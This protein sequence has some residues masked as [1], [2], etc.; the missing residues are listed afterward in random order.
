MKPGC[1][2]RCDEHRSSDTEGLKPV[3][4][5]SG[6]INGN[7]FMVDDGIPF[8]FDSTMT[9]HGSKI[10]CGDS[11]FT[12]IN[13]RSDVSCLDISAT[14]DMT[15]SP[16]KTNA[17]LRQYLLDVISLNNVNLDKVLP[18][19][20]SGIKIKLYYNILDM[21]GGVVESRSMECVPKT[22]KLHETNVAD[23][24]VTS[25]SSYMIADI[26]SM[27]YAGIYQIEL[28]KLEAIVY[29]LNTK[30]YLDAGNPFYSWDQSLN[31]VNLN[32][33]GIESAE[34]PTS[35]VLIEKY[36]SYRQEFTGNVS[37]RFKFSF[38]T[39]L[40]NFIY[41]ANN[42]YDIYA[43]LYSTTEARIKA[44]EDLVA[45]LSATVSQQEDRITALENRVTTLE[46]APKVAVEYAEGV[47]LHIGELTWEVVGKMYQATETF[48]AS[49][50]LDADV[51]AGKLIAIGG[52][53][54][55]E[56]E[57]RVDT[58]ET[59]VGTL[60]TSV[61]TLETNVGTIETNVG[62]LETSVGTLE[63]TVNTV[64]ETT[65]PAMQD[66]ID[67][68]KDST[69]GQYK[70]IVKNLD[71]KERQYV[72]YYSDAAQIIK[73]DTEHSY[74][75]TPG[76]NFSASEVSTEAFKDCTNLK[77]IEFPS[78]TSIS[79]KSKAFQNTGITSLTL[80]RGISSMQANAFSNCLD[81]T[82]VNIDSSNLSTNSE[83]FSGCTNLTDVTITS[84][85]ELGTSVFKNTGITTLTIPSSCNSL[86]TAALSNCPSLVTVVCNANKLNDYIFSG[87]NA[88]QHVE[89][90]S[91][92]TSLT[93]NSFTGT[94]GVS[95]DFKGHRSSSFKSG[96]PWGAVD[97]TF[98]YA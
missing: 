20:K 13:R 77:Y 6:A 15:D 39:Y 3:Y 69:L 5:V 2:I 4:P 25:L 97:G 65:L 18:V 91:N 51:Q 12:R 14:V 98:T 50:D 36:L 89:L 41:T 80:G 94:N 21:N 8:I 93:S 59:N 47:E 83:A 67:D 37:T 60:D 9:T 85:Y 87:S 43:A 95:F 28:T 64:T 26:P 74:S 45:Q 52:G 56:L 55:S 7:L 68:I 78:N 90:G 79:I 44:L 24:F 30:D 29:S 75:I 66:E 23:Y 10:N 53:D 71:T 42:A 96:E 54:T 35:A 31:K 34:N 62:T 57:T 46:I 48:T 76:P 27:D 82:T 84:V 17:V 40:S 22:M 1:D 86:N 11:I 88:L 63:T 61:E 73:N 58:L 92:C 49:G 81:L 16:I 72:S 70:L 38:V 33:A 32:H 19:F